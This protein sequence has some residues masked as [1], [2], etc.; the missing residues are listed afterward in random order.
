MKLQHMTWVAALLFIISCEPTYTATS[1]SSNAAYDVPATVQSA[2]TTQYPNAVSVTWVNPTSVPIVIDRD[3]SGW[4]ATT[5]TDY[6]V[7]FN[8]DGADYYAW[9]DDAG[10]WIGTATIISNYTTL[11][12]SV[13]TYITNTFPG[14]TISS[15]QREMRNNQIAYDV[16]IKNG[17][18]KTKLLL[19]ANG[20]V[21]KRKDKV[22]Q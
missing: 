7:R 18:M 12:A 13:N 9:Y 1:T 8:T 6:V 10:N 14:Y 11:P 2:F 5:G 22:D 3:F 4:T 19:D 17:N 16:E 15:V 21:I 20:N